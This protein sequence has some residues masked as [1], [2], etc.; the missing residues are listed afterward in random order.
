MNTAKRDSNRTDVF[1]FLFL[2]RLCDYGA[3]RLELVKRS[4]TGYVLANDGV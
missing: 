3:A 2:E 4:I 1:Y